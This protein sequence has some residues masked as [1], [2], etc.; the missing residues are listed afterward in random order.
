[1][2]TVVRKGFKPIKE[3]LLKSQ[4]YK[5]GVITST[6]LNVFAK[7]I[8]FLNNLLI[9]FYFGANAGT[10]IYFYILSV[11]ALITAS[12]NG[13][14]YYVLVPETMKIRVQK[15]EQEAQ[16]FINFFICSYAIIGILIVSTGIGAPLFFYTL[17]SKYDINLLNSN[18]KLLYLGSLIIFFQLINNLFTAILTSY[19]YFSAP[20]ISG[21][22]NS[23]SAILFTLFFN[24]TLGI[25]GTITGITIGYAV[26]FFLLISIMKKRLNWKFFDVKI[27]KDKTVWKYI[28]LMQINILPIWVRSYF[29]I[30]FLTGMGA[31]VVTSFN[32]AQMMA[33]LPEIFFLSQVASV[34]GIKFSELAAKKDMGQTNDLLINIFRTLLIII[35]PLS[36]IMTLANKEIIQIAFERGDFKKNSIDTTAFCFFYFSLL[37]PAKIWDIIFSR[38]FTSFQLYGISTVYAISAHSLVTLLLYVLTIHFQL[39]GFFIALIIGSYLVLPATFICII[40]QRM[41]EIYIATI[42]KDFIFI[43]IIGMII[44]FISDYLLSLFIMNKFLK[45]AAASVVV[46]I[47]FLVSVN[48]IIDLKFQKGIILNLFSKKL[49]K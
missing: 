23:V 31:G 32:L 41:R 11:A 8:G 28:G 2:V 48:Y 20:I 21:L 15:T 12:I 25:G 4:S 45:I 27:V 5:R 29:T 43:I 16:R 46:F 33:V 49:I 44:Y 13:I 40:K 10:D 37:L 9:A 1:M 35:I 26:N 42:I 36:V 18:Q 19:K 39:Y 30:F 14:D 34:V 22:I 38:L 6:F 3:Y 47:L 7:G 24:D 17:F